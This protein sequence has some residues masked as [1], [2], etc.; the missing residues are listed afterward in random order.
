MAVFMTCERVLLHF[1]VG[2]N[3]RGT[4]EGHSAAEGRKFDQ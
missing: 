3:Q 1:S 4:G 2:V